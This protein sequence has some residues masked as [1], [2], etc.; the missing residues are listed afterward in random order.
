MTTEPLLLLN[1]HFTPDKDPEYV[2]SAARFVVETCYGDRKDIIPTRIERHT[3]LGIEWFLLDLPRKVTSWTIDNG[4]SFTFQSAIANRSSDGPEAGVW[5]VWL[6]DTAESAA[7]LWET[8]QT[9][10]EDTSALIQD[11]PTFDDDDENEDDDEPDDD[12]EY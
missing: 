10:A 6:I 9:L 2:S 7:D 12:N 4:N 5:D 1:S 8:V 11:S 3:R